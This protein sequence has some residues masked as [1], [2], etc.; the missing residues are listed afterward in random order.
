MIAIVLV[1]GL[2]LGGCNVVGLPFLAPA[3]SNTLP[4]SS[5]G[6][7]RFDMLHPVALCRSFD[8]YVWPLRFGQISILSRRPFVRVSHCLERG[9]TIISNMEIKYYALHIHAV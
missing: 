1:G 3:H 4:S 2:N 8:L 6:V 9:R 7:Y 5:F